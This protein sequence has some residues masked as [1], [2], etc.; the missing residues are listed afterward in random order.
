MPP[1]LRD[2]LLLLIV[3][4]GGAALRL[5]R[6][7][8]D[9]LWYDETVS[10]FL[11]GS[12]L[13]EL[14]RHTAGD[15]HPPLYYILLRGWL[16][17]LGYPTGHADPTGNGL[18]FAAGFFS[19][20]FGV[21][22]IGLT[23]ALARRFADARAGLI[24][25]ALVALSPYHI[26]Y[27]QEVR[28]YTFGA[29]LGA[30]ATLALMEGVRRETSGVKRQTSGAGWAWGVYVV[31]AAAGMYTLY[32]FAFLLI[33]L[34]LW[35]LARIGLSARRP[36]GRSRLTLDVSRL[37][38]PV[39]HLLLANLAAGLLY[40]PWIPIAWRQATDP[41]VP[42]WRLAPDFL[43]ALAE[44]WRA[45]VLG[46]AAPAWTWPVALVVLAVYV[47][48]LWALTRPPSGQ[49]ANGIAPSTCD[50]LLLPVATFGPLLLILLISLLTPLYHVRYVFT[51]SPAFYVVGGAGLT[52]LWAAP[53]P[54]PEA[55]PRPRRRGWWRLAA[56]AVAAG[57][58]AGAGA[59]LHTFWF[60]PWYRADDHRAAVR[61]LQARWRPGDVLLLNA[62]YVYPPLF[63]Y[64]QGP[65]AV[66]SRLTEPLP[67][68]RADEAL[69][70]VMTGHLADALAPGRRLGW[71]DPRSDFFAMSPADA[72]RQLA[73]LFRSFGRVWHY[74][75][76]DTVND[77]AGRLRG[78]LADAGYLFE[79]LPF[80]GEANM[81][82]Q[83]FLPRRGATWAADRPAVRYPNGARVQFDA[84]PVTIAAGE[85]LY[86]D[87]TWRAEAPISAPFG[88][89]L[90]L[91]GD[92]GATWAQ[93]TDEKPFGP[94]F[95]PPQW[96]VGLPLRQPVRVPIL[97]GTPPGAYTLAL[98]IYDPLTGAA[99]APQEGAAAASA[100]P[101]GV[102]LRRVTVTRGAAA[103][104]PAL[105]H[106]GPLALIEATSAATVI[107]PGDVVP[108][109]LLWQATAAAGEPLVVVVQ[110]LAAGDRLMANLEEQPLQGRYPTQNWTAAELVRDR[111]AL[112]VPK[113]AP[114]GT[115]RLIV[116]VYRAADRT[117]FKTRIGLGGES[118]YW[119]IKRL[120]IRD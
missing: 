92:D 97:P 26:W 116:G 78:Q 60:D 36:D 2:R 114:A 62:G 81:R 39:S 53:R 30:V 98:L 84:A 22:L 113:D 38:F 18:E 48:G 42:P 54:R 28:M 87:L 100:V 49:T 13:P 58:L 34:N 5:F 20:F 79:D 16:I 118:D 31:A 47:A 43:S 85:T 75:V 88:V 86:A 89:S 82:L 71:D 96:P 33:A 35:A 93:P 40:A 69:V 101:N 63:T 90:R 1:R 6:L 56:P 102:N 115:Y 14:I 99:L 107:S 50:V 27:S 17:V 110:L 73:A 74:R 59:S 55:G 119:T 76:Y 91:V 15:I 57:W 51:Y 45:L 117:R 21:L 112:Q 80:A 108:V 23:Y 44:S 37:T 83:G 94:P 64:W 41:P 77:P 120:T 65:I 95:L 9:S 29:G 52:W 7:A 46:Q 66:R 11:A 8:A 109:E 25:A 111:H 70:I 24:A 19:L 105:A 104:Q 106:F 12:P 68:P 4:L 32:Y 61:A 3:L 67:A 103:L 10:T 72:D